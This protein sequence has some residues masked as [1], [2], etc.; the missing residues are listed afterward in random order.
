MHDKSTRSL[1]G[2]QDLQT[3][4]SSQQSTN[5]FGALPSF[6]SKKHPVFDTNI[7][8]DFPNLSEKSCPTSSVKW[9]ST[10]LSSE[11]DHFCHFVNLNCSNS[12]FKVRE[13]ETKIGWLWNAR[14]TSYRKIH[15][16]KWQGFRVVGGALVEDRL[17]FHK[18][19]AHRPSGTHPGSG[20]WRFWAS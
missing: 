11:A 18:I 16:G 2:C 6:W 20:N 12:T 1:V 4:T 10:Y 17:T 9:N 13:D 3:M 19:H 5:H 8:C 15:M 7:F 14:N